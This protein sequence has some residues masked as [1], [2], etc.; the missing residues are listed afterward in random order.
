MQCLPGSPRRS[1]PLLRIA[2]RHKGVVGLG[3]VASVQARVKWQT[4]LYRDMKTT[5]KSRFLLH[6]LVHP[7]FGIDS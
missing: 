6:N 3:G 2:G 4:Q 5:D 1:H 7:N